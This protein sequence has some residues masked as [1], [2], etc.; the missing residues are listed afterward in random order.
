MD[1]F[2][3]I[4]S[5]LIYALWLCDVTVM[6]REHV[7]DTDKIIQNMLW[8]N[9]NIPHSWTWQLPELW[10][11]IS[12]FFF[13]INN[14]SYSI[15]TAENEWRHRTSKVFLPPSAPAHWVSQG[16]CGLPAEPKPP[17][18]PSGMC[19][20]PVLGP[21]PGFW[22]DYS[23]SPSHFLWLLRILQFLPW[24]SKSLQ[25][26]F[27]ISSS[28]GFQNTKNG[29]KKTT[30]LPNIFS[31]KLRQAAYGARYQKDEKEQQALKFRLSF[32]H[33]YPRFSLTLRMRCQQEFR[34]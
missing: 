22:A 2:H 6:A 20:S 12:V 17:A 5:V 31:N 21:S 28:F 9:K 7:R 27:C 34:S 16:S 19:F 13:L 18:G 4:L 32:I 24:S 3:L 11:I 25:L 33:S 30:S 10:E 14:L 15:S 8:Y 29:A 1:G 26:C 23:N